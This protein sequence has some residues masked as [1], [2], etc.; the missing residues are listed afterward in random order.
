MTVTNIEEETQALRFG[1]GAFR[2]PRDVL[3]VRGPDAETYLQGQLSQ[4]VAALVVGASTDALLLEPDG[5][6]TALLRV[7]R[8]DGQG[9]VLDL[10]AGFGDAVVARL[11][12]FL[13]IGRAS[14]RERV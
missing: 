8:T 1:A 2:A 3:A 13:Q 6:L 9:F 10:D 14:C 7:T 11:R 4:D 12:R 5:K